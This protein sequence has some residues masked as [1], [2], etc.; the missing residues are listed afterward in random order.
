MGRARWLFVVAVL[1]GLFWTAFAE[2]VQHARLD[3]PT[4][5]LPVLTKAGCNAGACHGAAVGQ[6]GFKLSLLGYDSEKDYETITRESSGRRIDLSAPDAS[7]FLLKPTRQ[8]DHDGGRRIKKDS[9]AYFTLKRWIAAG[10]PYG[11]RDLRVTAISVAPNDLLL[12]TT[13]KTIELRVTATLSDGTKEDVTPLALY[14]SNDDGVAEVNASGLV[15]TRDRGLTSI[16]VRYSGQVAAARVAVPLSDAVVEASAFPAQNFIDE[17]V[18]AELRRLRIPPSPL[19]EDAEFLRR[20][21]LDVIGCLPT[22]EKVRAFLKEPLFSES[23]SSPREERVGRGSRREAT[24]ES[25]PRKRQRVIDDL[26]KREE[27]VDFWTMKFADLLLINGKRGA[28]NATR[29]YHLWL[30]EQV[31]NNRPFDQVARELITAAGEITK[32]GPAN[33]FTLANDPRDLGEHAGTIFLGTQIACARCHA[34][35]YAQWTQEDYHRF[36]AFFARVS[37][38]G[39]QVRV[40]DQGEVEH[41]KTGKSLLPKPLGGAAPIEDSTA[42]R[43][44]ALAAWLTS[45]DNTTFAQAIVNRIWKH[46][47]GRGLTEPVDDL[48]PTNP[49]SN[50]EL[51]EALAADFVANG[52]DVRR[53]IRTIVSARTYQL[54]SRANE[55]N[56]RDD[57]FF[58]RAY[59]KPLA[60][61]VLADAIAQAT[62]Q[63][64]EFAGYPTG[65]RSVQ[66]I[67]AQTPSYALDVFGRCSRERSCE[68]SGSGGGGLAQA[69]HLINGSTVNN[70]LREGALKQLLASARSDQELIEELY[71]RTLSRRASAQEMAQWK[72]MLAG[73][74]ARGEI[75]EDLLWALLNSREFAFNH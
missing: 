10:V 33:F 51:L 67:G 31:A 36:A 34:H 63:P 65:T 69:L 41:P 75:A 49:P 21:Y 55:I 32:T 27:F 16:M 25:S 72:T 40:R 4:R 35:P 60:A 52:Y 29:T 9:E 61:Q 11:P 37:N 28:E 22:P 6:G 50:P 43:R 24:G 73:P 45:P 19:S 13:N 53:L 70:K 15:T 26:L 57:R 5:I 38:E 2:D 64:E 20:V 8:I 74:N 23:S 17:K 46:L 66:L 12:E 56:R 14:T 58:S 1:S 47:L 71:L 42:D 3:F 18:F 68:S 44:A 7:L 48:R 54:S 39:G 30:R 62:G 59:L